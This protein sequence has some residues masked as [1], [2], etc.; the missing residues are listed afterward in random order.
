MRS[1]SQD[2]NAK[3]LRR[4]VAVATTLAVA[5][6][7]PVVP[8]APDGPA[9]VASAQTAVPPPD[10]VSNIGVRKVGADWVTDFFFTK[11][12]TLRTVT[13]EFAPPSTT[14]PRNDTAPLDDPVLRKIPV[15]RTYRLDHTRGGRLL[16][17]MNVVG[18]RTIVKTTTGRNAIKIVFELPRDVQ[19][20]GGN[21]K[22]SFVAPGE[23]ANYPIPFRS[24]ASGSRF[25]RGALNEDPLPPAPSTTTTVTPTST[26]YTTPTV[27]ASTTTRTVIPSTHTTT[28]RRTVTSTSTVVADP[29]TIVRT[30][31]TTTTPTS[32]ATSTTTF[33]AAPVTATSTAA[34]RTVTPVR[35]VTST[36]TSTAPAVTTTQT[37]RSITVT[38]SATT[39]TTPTLVEAPTTVTAP[40]TTVTRQARPVTV[41]ST[42][43]TQGADKIVITPTT[44]TVTSRPTVT[45]TRTVAGAPSTVTARPVTVTPTVT[46]DQLVTATAAPVTSTVTQATTVTPTRT[47]TRTVRPSATS[48]TQPSA[49]TAPNQTTNQAT[50]RTTPQ[51]T[52]TQRNDFP[53]SWADV[54]TRAGELVVSKP[55]GD[56]P[57][58]RNSQ[59]TT[60]SVVKREEGATTTT[61]PRPVEANWITVE[62]DG[63]LV[64]APP[65]GTAPGRY[66]VVVESAATGERDTIT[67]TV[68]PAI[69]MSERYTIAVTSVEAP[70]GASR[71]APA[72]RA[73]AVE[74]GFHYADRA[75]PAGTT[76]EVDV[77]GAAVDKQGRV[78]YTPPVDAKPGI[79]RVPVKVTFPDGSTGFFEAEFVVGEPLMADRFPLAYENGVS[80]AAGDT[81]AVFAT[82]DAQLPEGT[83]FALRND[84]DLGGWLVSVDKRTGAVRVV[85][86]ASGGKELTVPIVAYFPDGSTRELAT[87]VAVADSKKQTSNRRLAYDPVTATRGSLVTLDVK[88]VVPAGTTFRLIDTAEKVAV[89]ATTGQLSLTV[90]DGA[91]AGE[92]IELRVRAAY[93]DGSA[94]ELVGRVHVVDMATLYPVKFDGAT[95]EA[96][97][98]LNLAQTLNVPTGTRFSIPPEF[99]ERGWDVSVDP[100]TGQLRVKADANAVGGNQVMVPVQVTYPDGSTSV[101]AVPVTAPKPPAAPT[102]TQQPQD[103]GS[104]TGTWIAVVVGALTALAGAGFALWLNRDEVRR[105]LAQFGIAL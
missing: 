20:L 26:V 47:V 76:F 65:A 59:F 102:P 24:T 103:D 85:A 23:G 73:S 79:V 52:T 34:T 81:A 62:D 53:V 71:T 9:S 4:S 5:V 2:S 30:S 88:G 25:T 36:P 72:P 99:K 14:D 93:P 29:T 101:V 12:M 68:E 17:T 55:I 78:T 43:T 87:K 46:R 75:L 1:H 74:G 84:A 32:T 86:P 40:S 27:T 33:T 100:A 64:V 82:G 95:A 21:E 83:T 38:P 56:A 61:N 16:E 96:N 77:P 18:R 54:R 89:N 37:P 11:A 60:V 80:V 7:G 57:A 3:R 49:T 50:P 69:P 51:Q 6:A 58:P 42:T 104:S 98:S 39:T 28:P 44:P 90:P 91:T 10:G 105:A 31:Y 70:A 13:V 92:T 41:T 67:V 63:T 97:G 22:L 48:S 66:E 45:P 94:T 15:E 35:I 8:L 19:I